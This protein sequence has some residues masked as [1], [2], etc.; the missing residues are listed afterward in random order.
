MIVHAKEFRLSCKQSGEFY[1]QS[2]RVSLCK[3]NL[4][5]N[6]EVGPEKEELGGKKTQSGG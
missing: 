3:E 1:N 6:E 4:S 5:N 2:N